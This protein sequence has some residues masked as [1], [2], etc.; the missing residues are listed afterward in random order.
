MTN[1]CLLIKL[2]ILKSLILLRSPFFICR[3]IVLPF[4]HFR[5]TRKLATTA[6]SMAAAPTKHVTPRFELE[7]NKWFIEHQIGNRS[8][9]VNDTAM[10][11]IIY[12]YKCTD[13]TV[14]V[15]GKVSASD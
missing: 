6:P 2:T 12:V 11:Q 10:K 13:C 14:Q 15:K 4:Y 3:F 5:S 9:V 1:A 8:L 7:G